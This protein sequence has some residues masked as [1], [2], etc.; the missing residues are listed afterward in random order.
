MTARHLQIALN[1]FDAEKIFELENSTQVNI[2]VDCVSGDNALVDGYILKFQS[3]CNTSTL[4]PC[5]SFSPGETFNGLV[6]SI[7]FNAY[8]A[9]Y[10]YYGTIYYTILDKRVTFKSIDFISAID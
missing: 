7:R 9:G 1:V 6:S 3:D 10:R 8:Q 5:V 2:E 4:K